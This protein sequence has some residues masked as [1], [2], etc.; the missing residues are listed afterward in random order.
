MPPLT[1]QRTPQSL[2]SEWSR[3][4]LGPTI[5]IH[6][7]AKPLMRVMYHRAV[8]DLIK[9]QQGIPLSAETMEIYQSYLGWKYVAETTKSWILREI[10]QRA[11]AEAE[12]QV[13]AE[14]LLS[15]DGL[16][17][18]T[19]VAVRGFTARILAELAIHPSTRGAVLAVQPCARLVALLHD[20]DVGVAINSYHAL[21]A[22]SRDLDGARALVEGG[23]LNFILEVL[24]STN[25]TV[26]SLTSLLL[27]QL[28]SYSSTRRAVIA[29]K[30]CARLVALLG[31]GNVDV[32]NGTCY[33]LSQIVR[34]SDGAKAIVEAGA[35]GL[36]RQLLE[37]KDTQVREH[38]CWILARLASY[39]SLL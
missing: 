12:A 35:L 19:N 6:A 26:R 3:N 1:R 13:A 38:S 30:S 25:A 23:A 22:I 32:V 28:A 5:S 17:E 33:A 15:C 37:S 39:S 21:S 11:L 29:V 36:L 20:G 4:S 7:L 10:C 34:D 31:D 27:A 18:S 16:F 14:F 9:R 8:L 24:E 2:H